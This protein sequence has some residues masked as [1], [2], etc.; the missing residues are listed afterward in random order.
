MIHNLGPVEP[1]SPPISAHRPYIEASDAAS[2]QVIQVERL[3][4]V[5]VKYWTE[6]IIRLAFSVGMS[7]II[8]AVFF[9]LIYN[10]LRWVL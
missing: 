3:N 10:C 8:L 5:K 6:L 9:V 7:G 1:I 2:L 4:A